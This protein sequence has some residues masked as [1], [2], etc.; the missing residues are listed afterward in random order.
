VDVVVVV[1]SFGLAIA[2]EEGGGCGGGGEVYS[3]RVCEREV[4]V[5]VVMVAG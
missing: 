4:A 2:S 5:D 3:A 1:S